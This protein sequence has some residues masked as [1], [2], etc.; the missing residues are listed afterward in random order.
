MS[1]KIEVDGELVW[2]NPNYTGTPFPEGFDGK[3]TGDPFHEGKLVKPTAAF[4]MGR[5]DQEGMFTRNRQ[6]FD[7]GRMMAD[8]LLNGE[9]GRYVCTADELVAKR[10]GQKVDEGLQ[11]P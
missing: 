9:W 7:D 2:P 4:F 5:P 6:K 3:W 10:G 1:S 8:V 11:V